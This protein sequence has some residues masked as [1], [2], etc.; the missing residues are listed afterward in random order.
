MNWK[1]LKNIQLVLCLSALGPIDIDLAPICIVISNI[2]KL[3]VCVPKIK[4]T[5]HNHFQFSS[6]QIKQTQNKTHQII[7]DF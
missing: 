7:L 1:K 6:N 3:S 2:G 5:V 4:K